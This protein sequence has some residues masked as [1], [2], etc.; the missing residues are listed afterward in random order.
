MKRNA[1]TPMPGVAGTGSASPV[2]NG[3][4]SL[5]WMVLTSLVVLGATLALP[6]ETVAMWPLAVLAVGLIA[7]T[8]G[9]SLHRRSPWLIR[10]SPFLVVAEI[11]LLV[12]STGGPHSPY[13]ALY[14]ALLVYAAVYHPTRRLVAI[15]AVA[16]AAAGAPYVTSDRADTTVVV[17]LG[18]WAISCVVVH[19]LVRELRRRNY[20]VGVEEQRARSLFEHSPFLVYA[21]D[22]DG[23]LTAVNAAG[24]EITGYASE[25]LIGRSYE[26][27]IDPET[28]PA[29]REQFDRA[30]QGAAATYESTII[31]GDGSAM[32]TVGT[33]LPIIVDTVVVGV[34]GAAR[35]ISEVKAVQRKLA[36]QVMHDP[37]TGLGNRRLLAE[38]LGHELARPGRR[39]AD[40]VSLLVLDLDGFKTV[41]D[42]LG[43]GPGDDLLVRVADRLRG[44][45]RPGDTLVRLGGD[46]FAVVLPEAGA[47]EA[48]G[49]AER[50]LQALHAPLLVAGREIAVGASIG[51]AAAPDGPVSLDELLGQADQAMYEAK[52]GGRGR[53]EVFTPGLRSATGD[54]LRDVDPAE[55]R[56]WA[57]YVRALRAEIAATKDAGVLP[58]GTR[59]PE[60]VQRT[61]QLLLT[62]IDE[63]PADRTVVDLP[64]PGLTA[65]QEF[66][67]HHNAVQ[68]WAD[69][70]VS[71]GILDVEPSRLARRF[72]NRLGLRLT[73]PDVVSEQLLDRAG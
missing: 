71:D 54:V 17:T 12:L 42:V 73:D 2:V 36:H 44:C 3:T 55:C 24:R 31:T 39:S 70:L 20:Q 68:H 51:I 7:A 37:M 8:W 69:A 1:G 11:F 38:R 33:F 45:I 53:V 21:M 72:W 50:I 64:L 4:T 10:T 9:I 28:I 65:L 34:Y 52:R 25:E 61:L 57:A 13:V 27:F 15:G 47:E 23:V 14:G 16:A 60:S 41:N 30:V 58:A 62:A 46:E 35:D 43:H 5:W 49:V 19:H 48:R 6:L 18:V 32:E 40:T 56:A 59:A 22:R 67:Y 66:F 29:V 26:N 63:V